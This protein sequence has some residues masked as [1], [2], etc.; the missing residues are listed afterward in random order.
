M[1]YGSIQELPENVRDVLPKHAQDIHK[2]VYSS[3]L[4]Q[5]PESEDC[6][7]NAPQEEAS[8]GVA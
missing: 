2:A 5:H 3:A 7:D 4:K 1:P 8:A 6:D